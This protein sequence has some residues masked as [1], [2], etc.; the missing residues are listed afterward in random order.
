MK[1]EPGLIE[2][3]DQPD[4]D[5]AQLI[6]TYRQFKRVNR[7][8]ARPGTLYARY[9]RP[10][11]SKSHSVSIL[12]IGSGGGDIPLY[13]AK[14]A[15]QDGFLIRITAIDTDQRSL[16][17]SRKNSR[18]DTITYHR[19]A[20]SEIL[21]DQTQYDLVISNHLLHHL[22]DEEIIPFL[23]TT[24]QVARF[25]V[26]LSDIHRSE[27]SQ[28]MFKLITQPFFHDSFVVEDGLTSIRRSYTP[29]ELS[30]ILP[31]GWRIDRL[32]PYRLIAVFHQPQS[33]SQVP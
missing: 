33:L 22:P 19:C 17:F 13:I 3:M 20:I 23:Q 26:F 15:E 31:E 5:P 27:V 16:E 1:R 9:I 18:L 2:R 28:F 29:K 8:F 7:L 25:A 32:F 10:Y 11:L 21:A 12:D 6:N 14:R 24:T 30:L 4:C